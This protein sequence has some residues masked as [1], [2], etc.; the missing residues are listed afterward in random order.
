MRLGSL[1]KRPRRDKRHHKST[2]LSANSDTTYLQSMTT[3]MKGEFDACQVEDLLN[4]G[5]PQHKSQS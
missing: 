1:G 2:S 5:D 3:A 4:L